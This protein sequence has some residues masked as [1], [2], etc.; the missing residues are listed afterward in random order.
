MK[1]RAAAIRG[2]IVGILLACA[3]FLGLLYLNQDIGVRRS[4]LEDDIRMSQKI[5]EDW[6]VEG[7]A[8]DTV[9]AYISYPQDRSDHM[10]SVYVNRP[11]L[12][13]GYFFRG[14]GS[15]SGVE[16]GSRSTPSRAITRGPSSP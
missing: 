4:K 3:A 8:S 12:S 7:V 10:F 16:E 2:I 14:G 6:A 1:S 11:G 15:L 9:A 5:R 13:F